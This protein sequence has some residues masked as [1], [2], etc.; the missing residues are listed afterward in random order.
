MKK[1][2][3]LI[4]V[5]A[6]SFALCA[7]AAA[8]SAQLSAQ[9]LI[10]DGKPVDCEKYNIDGS[11]YF[12]LR[13]L[14]MLLS[15]TGSQF[16][17][18][19]D[20]AGGVVSITT[21]H[22]YTAPNG[23]ELEVGADN[24]A[25]ARISPQTILIDGV[26]Q[27]GLTVY[28]IGDS[29][30]FKLRELGEKLGFGVDYDQ[31]TNTAIITSAPLPQPEKLNVPAFSDQPTKENVL[32]LLD[33]YDPDGAF[34]LRQTDGYGM[35]MDFTFWLFGSRGVADRVGTAVHEQCHMMSH[36]KARTDDYYVG[37]FRSVSVGYTEYFN[38]KE[39]IPL[40]PDELKTSR[41]EIYIA[42]PDAPDAST[43]GIYGLLNEFM[44]YCWG[45]ND[46]VCL[47]DYYRDYGGND[48]EA[49]FQYINLGA[50]DRLA[51]AEFQYFILTY[52][53]YAEAN[54]PEIFEATVANAEL[55][56]AFTEL[57]SVFASLIRRYEE[58]LDE[59]ARILGDANISTKINGD[60]YYIG[61]RGTGMF[62]GSYLALMEAIAQPEYQRMLAA[63]RG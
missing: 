30:F 13:D 26:L 37:S 54:H 14:A 22:A 62:T 61:N 9:G 1:L 53:L 29:N 5:L 23:H 35:G 57:E 44:A 42:A 38:S 11:N 56:Q 58:S 3:A 52:L 7:P 47:F 34:I 21:K 36:S 27:S 59:I 40:I 24:S 39:M 8:F 60:Y 49:W 12:K 51:Y 50:N 32:A 43:K 20:S 10:V 25:S 55:R 28:N 15:G 4:L 45:L 19:W 31:E 63:L 48:A 16:D 33:A 18:G 17:V 2:F 6:L 46:T 41:Y